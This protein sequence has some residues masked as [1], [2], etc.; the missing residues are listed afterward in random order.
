M[1]YTPVNPALGMLREGK[2]K[3]DA[4]PG[5]IASLIQTMR[6]SQIQYR[7]KKSN[8][9]YFNM[10]SFIFLKPQIPYP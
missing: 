7:Q 8:Y 10:I 9:N 1:T 2:G 6:L 4:S 3:V 5:Y